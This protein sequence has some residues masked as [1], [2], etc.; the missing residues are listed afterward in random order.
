MTP[1]QESVVI[2]VVA[3]LLVIL[4]S[5]AALVSGVAFAS[6]LPEPVQPASASALAVRLAPFPAPFTGRVVLVGDS[7]AANLCQVKPD[8]DC[9]AFPGG[10]VA[11]QD[12][13][14]ITADLTAAANVQP[15]DF[16]VVSSISGWHSDGVDDTVITTR[17]TDLVWSLVERGAHVALLV[18]PL[19]WPACDVRPTQEAIALLGSN[20]EGCRTMREVQ[21]AAIR[22]PYV[23]HVGIA[24]PYLPDGVHQNAEGMAGTIGLL[25][26]YARRFNG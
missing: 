20:P 11:G 24:A 8:W 26:I 4:L 18:G 19:E 16:V 14:N 21:Y 7:I 9:F 22:M 3:A 17:L 1:R 6:P 23:I 5:L 2:Y 15:G 10:F 25:E 13:T 12:G